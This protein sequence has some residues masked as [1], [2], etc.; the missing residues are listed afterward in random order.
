DPTSASPQALVNESMWYA[1]TVSDGI[2]TRMDSVFVSVYELNC[3]EPD[4]FVPNAFTPNGDGNNDVLFVR[5]RFIT[6]LEFKI[7]D[8]WGEKVFETTDQA[9]GWDG[10]F[11]GEPAGA[12]VFVYHLRVVCEDGRSYFKKGN[13][14]LIR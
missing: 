1:V 3:E 8:R 14:T 7:F 10:T 11:R 5:G 13:V 9:V 2:C 4:I 6:D 12:A